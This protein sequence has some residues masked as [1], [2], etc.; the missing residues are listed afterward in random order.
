MI[1][2]GITALLP[3]AAFAQ[4]TPDSTTDALLAGILQAIKEGNV[5]FAVVIALMLAVALVRK[6]IA[7]KV[8]F[9]ATDT[10]GT[11]LNFVT[12][13]LV[14]VAGPVS[15]G[16]A[17]TFGVIKTAVLTAFATSGGW[18]MLKRIVFNPLLPKITPFIDEKV[19]QVPV[20]GLLLKPIVRFVL[21]KYLTTPAKPEP[22]A[23]VASAAVAAQPAIQKPPMRYEDD[24]PP[25][26]HSGP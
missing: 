17:L 7:P 21:G 12:V 22:L 19:G 16:A 24:I 25:S 6:T 2:F 11:L 20:L 8:A 10:G 5:G 9:F 18:T 23:S 26:A 4:L 1:L 3:F 15:A 13:A 14:M